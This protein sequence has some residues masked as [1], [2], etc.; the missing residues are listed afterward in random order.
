MAQTCYYS[1][2]V[3]KSVACCFAKEDDS[4]QVHAERY[5]HGRIETP[6]SGPR[7]IYA[8]ATEETF[9]HFFTRIDQIYT[10]IHQRRV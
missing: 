5:L 3:G 1:I 6:S 8:Y 7:K 9:P 2:Q 4:R 10:S